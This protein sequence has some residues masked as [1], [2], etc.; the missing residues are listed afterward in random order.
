V[1]LDVVGSNPVAR[2]RFAQVRR[3]CRLTA[4]PFAFWVAFGAAMVGAGAAELA[5]GD[6]LAAGFGQEV[7]AVAEH[8]RPLPEPLLPGPGPGPD[9]EGR[10][11][12]QAPKARGNLR[13]GLGTSL[14]PSHAQQDSHLK[15]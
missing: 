11:G 1:V 8:V 4:G 13:G 9:G 3:P 10:A 15:R 14:E 6:G 12:G 7:A 5:K 2:P